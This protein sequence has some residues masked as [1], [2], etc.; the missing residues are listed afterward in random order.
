MGVPD[1]NP[2]DVQAVAV[3]K[4]IELVSSEYVKALQSKLPGWKLVPISAERGV[5]LTRLKDEVYETLRFMRVFLKP[6]GKEADMADPLIVKAGSDVGMVCDAIHRDWR[7]RFRYANVW[8]ASAQFPGQKVGLD[9]GLQDS[10]VLTIVL[11][12]G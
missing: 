7:G 2:V 3:V 6:Q 12:K 1:G 11:K 4:K 9:H 5:G 10:D 8:G